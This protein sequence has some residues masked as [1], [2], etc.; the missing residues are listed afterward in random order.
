MPMVRVGYQSSPVPI[1]SG[2]Y[3]WST[4]LTS[5]GVYRIRP[6][7]MPAASICLEGGGCLTPRKPGKPP[8]ESPNNHLCR[9]VTFTGHF[10]R[11]TNTSFVHN[12]CTIL[13]AYGLAAY[14]GL[15]RTQRGQDSRGLRRRSRPP[16]SLR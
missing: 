9:S 2:R 1:V 11:N 8:G 15:Q 16:S 4:H 13:V 10:A 14:V 7:R 12:L 5:H 6:P 3:Q